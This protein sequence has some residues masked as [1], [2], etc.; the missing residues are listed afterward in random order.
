MRRSRA[1]LIGARCATFIST[2]I[3][4]R[5]WVL[6]WRTMFESIAHP[7]LRFVLLLAIYVHRDLNAPVHKAR[8]CTI[9]CHSPPVAN[10][11]FLHIQ[12][13]PSTAY[14]SCLL[15]APPE[16]PCIPASLIVSAHLTH[17]LHDV[18]LHL[19]WDY[20]PPI[21]MWNNVRLRN[22]GRITCLYNPKSRFPVSVSS[23]D[24]AI[25]DE[26]RKRRLKRKPSD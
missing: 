11:F 15:S 8:P 5:G 14:V 16:S 19:H 12:P 6:V 22:Q 3:R 7:M 2:T 1:S 24:N 17:T 20:R 13:N 18:W 21:V 10:I 25:E 26:T 4:T 23:D 9:S